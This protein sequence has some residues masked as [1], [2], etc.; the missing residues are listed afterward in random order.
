MYRLQEALRARDK[1]T[2]SL[3]SELRLSEAAVRAHAGQVSNIVNINARRMGGTGNVAVWHLQDTEEVAGGH[4]VAEQ[5]QAQM[6]PW[7]ESNEI[8]F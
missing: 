5:V 1:D 8:H 4:P 6:D 3:A 2:K 7:S